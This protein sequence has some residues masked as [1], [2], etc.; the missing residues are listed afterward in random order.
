MAA[1][2]LSQPFQWNRSS[3]LSATLALHALAALAILAPPGLV[4][5][6][7]TPEPPPLAISIKPVEPPPAPP[8]PVLEV[9]HKPKPQPRP[10]PIRRPEPVVVSQPVVTEQTPMSVPVEPEATPLPAQPTMPAETAPSALGYRSMKSVP[11]PRVSIQRRE[12]GTVMLRVL[13]GTD[14][15]PQD[16]RIERSSG[17]VALDRAAREAVQ[18]WR[19]EPGTRNGEPFAA[20]GLVPISFRLSEL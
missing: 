6:L 12:E 7:R 18:K 1:H 13:V 4:P 20:W 3:A 19:F 5:A 11:Y 2:V 16:I 17:H 14:G 9:R 10:Q 8:P 15:V